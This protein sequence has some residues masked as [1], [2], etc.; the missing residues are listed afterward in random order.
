MGLPPDTG[1]ATAWSSATP[2]TTSRRPWPRRASSPTSARTGAGSPTRRRRHR[3]RS[4]RSCSPTSSG[5]RPRPTPSPSPSPEP[6]ARAVRRRRRAPRPL[7]PRRP[8]PA[9]ATRASL[10]AD[11]A[12]A[13]P[14]RGSGSPW[15]CPGPARSTRR[16]HGAP[17]RAD[18]RPRRD[19]TLPGA[20]DDDAVDEG[21]A[22]RPPRAARR[23]AAHE[24][25]SCRFAPQGGGATQR[26]RQGSERRCAA[27]GARR[28]SG[29]M[30][31]VVNLRTGSQGQ[32]VR[33]RGVAP[34]QAL[35]QDGPRP[36]RRRL[37][38]RRLRDRRP[39]RAR[40]AV[41][42]PVDQRLRHLRR[43]E[44]RL[45][46]RVLRRQRHHAR[47]DDARGQRPGADAVRRHRLRHA[48]APEPARV[49]RPRALQLPWHLARDRCASSRARC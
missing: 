6:I 21:L 30:D 13:R 39:A 45:A 31:N 7:R 15:P 38:R 29:A 19:G 44:R 41:G 22:P 35:G 10:T 37:H 26:V 49:R 46:D 42:Q 20:G 17:R 34:A 40:P 16:G 3:R 9:A 32:V 12:R 2:R 48:A 28:L 23:Q 47:A 33:P 25:S 24:A 36:R 27:A 5:R 8:S 11:G 18:G 4:V 43:D 1:C 14:A